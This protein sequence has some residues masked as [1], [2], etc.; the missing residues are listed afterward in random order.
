LRFG[1]LL[2]SCFTSLPVGGVS[3]GEEPLPF[4][5]LVEQ[6]PI[7]SRTELVLRNTRH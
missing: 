6:T 7:P 3:H 1:Q 4:R 5:R 2:L